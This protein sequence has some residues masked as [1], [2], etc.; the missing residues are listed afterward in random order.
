MYCK[1]VF[2]ISDIMIAYHIKVFKHYVIQLNYEFI[3]MTVREY[4]ILLLLLSDLL[5]AQ[6]AK[7]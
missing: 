7:A 5:I 2:V 4:E 6:L 1:Q 3:I